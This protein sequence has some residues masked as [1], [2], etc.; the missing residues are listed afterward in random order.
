MVVSDA[1]IE[2]D[3]GPM[4][5]REPTMC[6]GVVP[7]AA[8]EP[9]KGRRPRSAPTASALARVGTG[10]APL[11]LAEPENCRR[12][13]PATHPQAPRISRPAVR[14]WCVGHWPAL[15]GEGHDVEIAVRV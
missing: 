15:P 13:R 14:S 3:A 1:L 7:S 10:T 2:R 6:G 8:R 5:G 11:P 4:R 9:G 12:D